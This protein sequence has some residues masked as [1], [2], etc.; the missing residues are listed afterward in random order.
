V[1]RKIDRKTYFITLLNLIL[2]VKL[3]PFR[4]IVKPKAQKPPYK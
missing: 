3:I 2:P 4:L 1:L